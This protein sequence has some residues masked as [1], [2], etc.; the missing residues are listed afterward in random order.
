M[1]RAFELVK[2]YCLVKHGSNFTVQY[3]LFAVCT[4]SIIGTWTQYQI[5]W[6]FRSGKQVTDTMVCSSWHFNNFVQFNK[7]WSRSNQSKFILNF[8]YN[9]VKKH[10]N[11]K[12]TNYIGLKL[13]YAPCEREKLVLEY[14]MFDRQG[15]VH[16]WGDKHWGLER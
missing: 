9:Q 8:H 1:S 5:L 6:S 2:N 11:N 13:L 3:L 7:S 15:E 12:L 4:C 10:E 14:L 16:F